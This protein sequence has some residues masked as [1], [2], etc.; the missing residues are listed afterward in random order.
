MS[1]GDFLILDREYVEVGYESESKKGVLYRI[2]FKSRC[3]QRASPI[4]I[5]NPH[6]K[7]PS[8]SV[9]LNTRKAAVFN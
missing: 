6:P 9:T 7:K 5:L 1:G 2:F 4:V 8:V 3:S